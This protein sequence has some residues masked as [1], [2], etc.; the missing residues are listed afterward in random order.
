MFSE[1]WCK[2]LEIELRSRKYSP[3]TRT[4]YIH[5]NQALCRHFQKV[6]EEITEEDIKAYAAYQEKTLNLS[7]SSINLALSAFKFFY[8]HI[9]NH[10][11]AREQHRPRQDKRLPIVLSDTEIKAM[12]N[13]EKI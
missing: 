13:T 10:D 7:S 6:P 11:I 5:Y 2:K 4:A 3:K 12:I 9:V 8:K 1:A